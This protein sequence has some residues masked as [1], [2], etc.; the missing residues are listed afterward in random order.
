[1]ALVKKLLNVQ[2]CSFVF[3]KI[4]FT[5]YNVYAIVINRI[6]LMFNFTSS[7]DSLHRG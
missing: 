1:M 5:I 7:L 3:D 4:L 2:V 6:E